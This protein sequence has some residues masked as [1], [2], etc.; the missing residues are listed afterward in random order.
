MYDRVELTSSLFP[1][2]FDGEVLELTVAGLLESRA[3]AV[4]AQVA[5]TAVDAAGALG[6]SW[7]HAEL[8]ADAQRLGLALSTRFAPGERVV[9]W[10]PNIPEWLLME[11]GCAVAGLVLVTANP[12]FQ[13]TELR[14]VLEQS[15]SVGLFMVTSHRGNPM[16]MIADEAVSAAAAV[17]REVVDLRSTKEL[18]AAGGRTA[19][20]PCVAPT[21]AAQIQYTSGTTG[22][23]KGAVLSHRGLVNN[24]RFFAHRA[25]TD[26]SSVYANFMPL[27]HTAGCATGAL[28]SLQAGCRMLLMEQFNAGVLAE[29]IESEGVTGFFAVPTMLV[30]LLESLE[31]T[32]RDVSSLVTITTGGAPVAPELV[33]RVRARLGCHLL[34]AFGQ[35]EA[36][37]MISLNHPDVPPQHIAASAGQPLPHT[38]VSI[39]STGDDGSPP[40]EVVPVGTMGEICVRS[41]GVMIAYNDNPTATAATI[42]EDRWLHTGDLGTLDPQGFLRITGRVKDMIIRGGE[43]HFPAEIEN[44][45]LQ[46]ESV[47]EVAVVGLPDPRWGEVIGAF[48]R[49]DNDAEL[50]IDALRAHCRSMLSPQKTPTVWR[51]V[52]SFPLTGSGKVRKYVIRE[53]FLARQDTADTGGNP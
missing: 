6:R 34:T 51:R 50:D 4:P 12:S 35:T 8:L 44:A 43:N 32:P 39:R 47:A 17:V 24:A 33:A 19:A 48:I 27:F 2:Q 7:S 40:N 26:G 13:A 22:F 25:L 18:F 28:G 21:D 52:E 46:H 3:A 42:D 37:P 15:G 29:R 36:S 30:A 49:T 9:V 41:F 38:E 53:Q 10:A 11:Y 16:A 20:L 1:A 45:L 31:Q 23:P 5:V 14:Y